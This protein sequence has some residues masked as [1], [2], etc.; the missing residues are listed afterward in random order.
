[1]Q[2]VDTKFM[3]LALK[4]ARKGLG[5][6]S[7][8]PAV[9]AVIVKEGRVVASGFHKQAGMPHAEVEAF[10][11]VGNR[12]SGATLYVTLEPCNHFG[13]TPPC[14]ELI[15][16]SGV[17]RVVVGM[18]D[19]NPLVTGGGC[20][21]LEKKGLEVVTGIL[22]EEFIQLNEAFIK[23]ITTGRPFVIAKSAITLD[24]WTA[25]SAH[26]SQWI[27]NEKSRGF[28]HRLR[29]RVDAVLMGIGTVLADDPA[30]T[31]RFRAKKGK[32]PIRIVV[33]TNFRTPAGAK[34]IRH[35]SAAPTIIAT[36][37]KG[38]C[39]YLDCEQH[40]KGVETL[41][42]PKQGDKL[43]LTSLMDKLG[44]K[45]ITSIL[46]EGGAMILGAMIRAQL[47]DKFYVFI[48][49]K[50]LGGGDGI[51]MAAGAGPKTMDG[52]LRLQG[53]RVRRFGDDV[54]ISGYPKY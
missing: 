49:P 23:F 44:E 48:A 11:K 34:V 6:T 39:S 33:D 28:V 17:K 38:N 42:C 12:A 50:I 2:K 13:K 29:D 43:D 4:E 35:E 5:R 53:M 14:T 24:G 37:V 52:S 32:D 1:M 36:S 40:P 19:P 27:T 45:S 26:H 15:L 21:Y 25:T 41:V 20:D 31:A 9:G 10:R 22:K 51:P 7:P 54:L 3:K 46:V 8:N 30:M 18:R 47:I 16:K